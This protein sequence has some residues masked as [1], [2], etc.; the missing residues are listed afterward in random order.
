MVGFVNKLAGL[1]KPR[2]RFDPY[3]YNTDAVVLN[4][5]Y[6]F[7]EVLVAADQDNV[8]NCSMLGKCDHIAIYECVDALLLVLCIQST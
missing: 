8:R 2:N 6:T 1:I 4:R 3:Q 5:A 7:T